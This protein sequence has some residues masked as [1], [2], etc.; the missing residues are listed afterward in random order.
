MACLLAGIPQIVFPKDLETSITT[1]KLTNLGVAV[2]I[3]EP[4]TK[5]T[6]LQVND[7][8]PKISQN[9][10]HQAKKLANWNQNFLYQVVESC[11]ELIN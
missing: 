3:L 4:F 10:Q 6:L 5:E 2:G 7:Y 9:A 8:L 1:R 11:L